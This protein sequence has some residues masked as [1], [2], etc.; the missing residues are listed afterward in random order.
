MIAEERRN[1]ILDVLHAKGALSVNDACALLSVSRM[2]VHRD[3]ETLSA[4]GLLRKVHGGAVA[5]GHVNGNGLEVAR[6]F[7][8]RK[9]ANADAKAQIAKRLASILGGARTLALD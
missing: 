4:A 7:T 8:E 3:L 5:I 6:S 9:P 2:T 1:K